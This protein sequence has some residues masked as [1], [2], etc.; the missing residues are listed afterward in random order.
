M[1]ERGARKAEQ[2]DAN[3]YCS[4]FQFHVVL[5]FAALSN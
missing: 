5:P 4:S 1:R 2:A 3:Q